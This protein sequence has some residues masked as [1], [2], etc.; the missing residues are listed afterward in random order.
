M[1]IYENVEP[2]DR[3]EAERIFASSDV[4]KVAH[5]LVAVAFFEQDWK[6][7][8]NKCLLFLDNVNS[9]I[10]GVAATC[11]GHIAR[12]HRVL[13]KDKVIQALSRHLTDI[14][15]KGQVQDAIDDINQFG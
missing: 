15:I 7:V 6:W 9:D 10:R 8:Q 4:N 13:E 11:L 5:T 14:A 12:V 2:I 1:N 3:E